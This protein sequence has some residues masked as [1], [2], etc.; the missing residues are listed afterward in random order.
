ML[1]AIATQEQQR[2]AA[3]LSQSVAASAKIREADR[4]SRRQ[5]LRQAVSLERR[6]RRS[7][8]HLVEQRLETAKR[9]RRQRDDEALLAR[10]W[11]LLIEAMQH[12]WQ[13]ADSRYQWCVAIIE[14]ALTV[15]H[16][17]RWQVRHAAGLTA[18]E[19]RRL[20]SLL[21][22]RKLPPPQWQQDP[23]TDAGLKIIADAACLDGTVDGLLGRR[24]G[25]E[26]QILAEWGRS[27]RHAAQPADG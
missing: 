19:K 3:L 12:R 8:L 18:A 21:T 27:S 5:R 2:C 11:P 17:G 23:D 15:L 22:A 16:E 10:A 24:A 14:D 13:D 25:I 6:R 7:A 9:L 26:G 4:S 20:G 1:E